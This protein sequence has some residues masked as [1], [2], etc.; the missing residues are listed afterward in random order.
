M[1]SLFFSHPTRVLGLYESPGRTRIALTCYREAFAL[2]FAI[3]AG[4]SILP[5]LPARIKNI[6]IRMNIIASPMAAVT[7]P[8]RVNLNALAVSS[9]T[10][11][12][13]PS[14]CI[15]SFDISITWNNSLSSAVNRV[16]TAAHKHANWLP[17]RRLGGRDR[18]VD[19]AV[20]CL[21]HRP[22]LVG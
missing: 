10:T 20:C 13:F 15:T 18:V 12:P 19:L 3:C 5:S 14:T 4:V 16:C 6:H 22:I 7:M 11:T 1:P 8:Q 21:P 2:L 9:R 17:D